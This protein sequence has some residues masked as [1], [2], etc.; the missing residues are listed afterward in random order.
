MNDRYDVVVVGGGPGGSTAAAFLAARGVRVAL[1]ERERFPRFHIGE[2][3]LPFNMGVFERLGIVDRLKAEFIEKWGAEFVS[4]DGRVRQVF[5]FEDGLIPGRP[6]CFEVLRSRFDQLLL[7]TAGARGAEVF[8]GH[9]V[10]AARPSSREG[11]ELRVRGDDGAERTVRAPLLIDAS[12]RDGLLASRGLPRRMDP[13]LRKA[14]VFAHFENVPRAPGR[15]AGNIVLVL[16][17]DAWFWFIPL[18]GATTSVGLVMDGWRYRERGQRP[19]E[20]FESAVALC[21]AASE[22]LR[23][24]RRLSP[25]RTTSDWSYRCPRV[26]GDGFLTVGDAAGFVDPVFSSGV[27]LAMSSGELAAQA[28][29]LALQR[30]VFSARAF[31][32]YAR[33]VQHHVR[34]YRRLARRFYRRGFTEVCLSPARR[35][36]LTPAVISLLA[37]CTDGG[38]PLRWR[39]SLF[40]T[41]VRLQPLFPLAPRRGLARVF[42]PPRSVAPPG[43]RNVC[44]P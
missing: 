16:L 1:F 30:G 3:L 27:Y 11:A 42:E 20:V 5:H 17:Q 12:G 24:A 25:V 15:D 9:T 31:R 32:D 35:L 29:A 33:A 4:S 21:P 18:A 6:M 28:A 43:S 38:W 37:G 34:Q 19:Q 36:R 8:Q 22:M 7:D 23:S 14:A 39:L 10:V 44:S 26:T 40:Y 13:R 2:S 41:V